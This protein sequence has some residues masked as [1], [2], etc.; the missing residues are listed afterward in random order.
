MTDEERIEILL[1]ARGEETTTGLVRSGWLEN[2]SADP[3][4]ENAAQMNSFRQVI[5]RG[6]IKVST[7]IL[8]SKVFRVPVTF[9]LETDREQLVAMAEGRTQVL[10]HVKH[11]ILATPDVIEPRFKEPR[12]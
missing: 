2:I 7:I 12:I 5:L 8:A 6:F 3:S 11:P 4:Q 9:W 1:K 10:Y